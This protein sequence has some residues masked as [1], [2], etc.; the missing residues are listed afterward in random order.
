MECDSRQSIWWE[1]KSNYLQ[2]PPCIG[3][4]LASQGYYQSNTSGLC[5]S[6]SQVV[7]LPKVRHF[8]VAHVH[9]WSEAHEIDCSSGGSDERQMRPWGLEMVSNTK[10]S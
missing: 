7:S 5:I 3:H 8:G 9:N 2:A 4:R 1:G 10:T 6:G